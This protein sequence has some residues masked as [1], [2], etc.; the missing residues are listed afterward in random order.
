MGRPG[1]KRRLA[2]DN[3]YWK[4]IGDGVGT[5][6]ACRRWGSAGPR[7]TTGRRTAAVCSGRSCR[8]TPLRAVPVA[9]GAVNRPGFR[10]GS[11]SW[12]RPR[13]GRVLQGS[14]RA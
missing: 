6:E 1:R 7:L 5:V 14:A 11:V 10:G 12:F 8:K 2:L 13:R 9:A 3:E 4:L